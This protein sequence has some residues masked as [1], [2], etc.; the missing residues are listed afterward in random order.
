MIACARSTRATLLGLPEDAQIAG[1]RAHQVTVPTLGDSDIDLLLDA[2]ERANR[3]GVLRELAP[4][5][6]HQRLAKGCGRQLLVAMIEATSGLRFDAKIDS[7]CRQLS[8]ESGLVYA[9]CAIA[10]F[11]RAGLTLQ[12]LLSAVHP[13]GTRVPERPPWRTPRIPNLGRIPSRWSDGGGT[14]TQCSGRRIGAPHL[15]V[16]TRRHEPLMQRPKG[17]DDLAEQQ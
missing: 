5:E 8:G 10:N 6:R 11:L 16:P 15:G 9:I 14:D 4:A 7:E 3:L 13:Q 12:E 2:L 1:D 17:A